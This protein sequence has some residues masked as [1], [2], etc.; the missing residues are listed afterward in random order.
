MS[1][2]DAIVANWLASA[3]HAPLA[4]RR[5]FVDDCLESAH[6]AHDLF[7]QDAGTRKAVERAPQVIQ[8]LTEL[9]AS[10]GG[11]LPKPRSPSPAA[12]CDD[13]GYPRP[14]ASD[15]LGGSEP[16]EHSASNDDGAA[17]AAPEPAAT[18]E[19]AESAANAERDEAAAR[20]SDEADEEPAELAS[21]T[22]PPVADD[23]GEVPPAEPAA[24]STGEP[25]SAQPSAEPEPAAEA[26]AATV[27]ANAEP[28]AA[29]DGS[30]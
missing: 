28:A 18:A 13:H 7:K 5:A 1:K 24:E 3:V 22:T 29:N 6:L 17:A 4:E 12:D 26:A 16:R 19:P 30:A 14:A 20:P 15:D 10:L 21:T 25:A 9:Q 8:Q 2:F 11:P 23:E 27:Q